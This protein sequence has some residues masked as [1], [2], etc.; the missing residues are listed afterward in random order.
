M[1]RDYKIMTCNHETCDGNF[2]DP[3][4]AYCNLPHAHAGE[5]EYR[6]PGDIN[7]NN[8]KEATK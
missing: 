2:D 1:T 3:S 7:N 5:H 8:N 4:Y 6:C